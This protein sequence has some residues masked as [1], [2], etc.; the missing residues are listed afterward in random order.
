MNKT[1][2]LALNVPLLLIL[3]MGC[4][5][6]F[7]WSTAPGRYWWGV[8][9]SSVLTFLSLLLIVN[10]YKLLPAALAQSLN[11]GVGF[12]FCQLALLAVY[13]EPIS[14]GGWLAMAMI[15]GGI[16]LFSFTK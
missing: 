12:I 15:A 1:L 3:Q 11:T 6:C 14:P 5:I 9:L 8:T 2:L 16:V 4:V 7:K 10:I 13:R